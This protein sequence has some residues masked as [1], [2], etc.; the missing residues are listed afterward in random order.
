MMLYDAVWCC[1]M[2]YDA[3]WCCMVLHDA[4]WSCMMLNDAVWWCM[5]LHDALW[6]CMMLHDAV[7]CCMMLYDAAWCCMMHYEPFRLDSSNIRLFRLKVHAQNADCIITVINSRRLRCE[8]TQH[9]WH[10]RIEALRYN[11]EGRGFDPRWCH[12]NFSLT[13]L[14]APYDHG[15]DSA[16]NRNEY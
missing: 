11:Q 4:V 3:A 14:P 15:V 8:N 16:F 7:W 9:A 13:I 12:W 6:C 10:R 2:L 1:M 5:M